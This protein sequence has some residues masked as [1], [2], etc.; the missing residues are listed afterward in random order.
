MHAQALNRL[1]IHLAERMTEAKIDMRTAAYAHAL[2]RIGE[3][4]EAHGTSAFFG[5][6]GRS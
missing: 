2:D 3:A 4:V 1:E 6:S 5:T